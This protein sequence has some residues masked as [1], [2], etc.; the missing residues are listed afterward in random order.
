LERQEN[1]NELG[2]PPH[3]T[4]SVFINLA[5][6]A[7]AFLAVGFDPRAQDEPGSTHLRVGQNGSVGWAACVGAWATSVLCWVRL[8][9]GQAASA[10]WAASSAG[11]NGQKRVFFSF[12]SD[13]SPGNS[14]NSQRNQIN[15]TENFR[16]SFFSYR[17]FRNIYELFYSAAYFD[18][19]IYIYAIFQLIM[20]PT[21][22]DYCLNCIEF[23]KFCGD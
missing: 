15:N 5:T 1:R 19:F 6:V 17:K 16:T 14:E 8:P 12:S 21:W 11:P 10:S 22:I 9:R 23:R 7:R 4:F 3:P 18:T 20:K 2:L 13:F